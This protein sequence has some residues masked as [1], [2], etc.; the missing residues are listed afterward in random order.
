MKVSSQLPV[1]APISQAPSGPNGALLDKMLAAERAPI[2][3]MEKRREGMEAVRSELNSFSAMVRELGSTADSIKLPSGFTKLKVESSHPEILDGKVTGAT[4]P[5]SY[6]FEVDGLASTQKLVEAGFPDADQTP[7]GFG[8]LGIE[9]KDGAI[10]DVTIPPGATLNDVANVINDSN[11]GVRAQVIQTGVGDEP[12]R[13]MIRN[14]T[15]GEDAKIHLDPDTTFLNFG[16]AAP[17]KDLAMKFE[18]VEVKRSGNQVND[19]VAGLAL[20][21]KKAEPGTKVRVD[22]RP[23]VDQTMAGIQ[24]FVEKYN[25]VA[26]YANQQ[27]TKKP[28]EANSDGSTNSALRSTMRSLQSQI[29]S[30]VNAPEGKV[31]TM[32]EIGITTNAK[33][34]E[35]MIDEG[36]VKQALNADYDGVRNLFSNTESGDG[37]AAKLSQAVKHL[38]DPASGS[39]NMRQKTL[40]RQI[41]DQDR[42]IEQRSKALEQRQAHVQDQLQR[43]EQSMA[44][45]EGQ[46]AELAA[47]LG[48]GK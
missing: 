20:E 9:G 27:F 10:K 7:V 38:Q 43:M 33:T 26:S 2:Q 36:K 12:Y 32:A 30:P 22:V 35:L 34:G 11:A 16:E 31:K 18:G 23:D 46:Q 44:R 40:N 8:Y 15:T 1:A 45:L 5:G 19:L 47:R 25:K 42:Q 21:T 37:L 29:A 13:L 4:T 3:A 14:E 39:L 41:E 28:G 17:A 6:E 48:G 24:Q